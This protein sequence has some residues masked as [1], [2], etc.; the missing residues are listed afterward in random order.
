MQQNIISL[1]LWKNNF[2]RSKYVREKNGI[3]F[4]K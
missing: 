3:W 1:M 2:D 4:I